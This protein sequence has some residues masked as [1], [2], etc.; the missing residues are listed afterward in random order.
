MLLNDFSYSDFY[1][2]DIFL[3]AMEMSSPSIFSSQHNLTAFQ[4]FACHLFHNLF[5]PSRKLPLRKQVAVAAVVAAATAVL[6][7]VVVV[8][9]TA[10]TA[11]K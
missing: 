6:V 10:V 7:A 8:V 2:S 4:F 9:A 3:G 11:N 1:H 5:I